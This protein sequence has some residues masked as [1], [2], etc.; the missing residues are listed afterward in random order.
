MRRFA[1]PDAVASL[2]VHFTRHR[3][4]GAG[5]NAHCIDTLFE[6]YAIVSY[7]KFVQKE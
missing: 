1:H 6:L 5:Y 4:L 7:E 3:A 2:R